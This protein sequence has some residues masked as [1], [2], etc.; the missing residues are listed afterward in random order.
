MK[1][2]IEQILKEDRRQMYLNNIIKVMKDDYPIIKNLKDYGFWEVLKKDEIEYVL[3]NLLKKGVRFVDSYYIQLLDE[4]DNLLYMEVEVGCLKGAF[5]NYVDN[6]DNISLFV[7]N[8]DCV[9]NE[10]ID[11][12]EYIEDLI[13]NSFEP[14]SLDEFLHEHWSVLNQTMKNDIMFLLNI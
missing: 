11:L 4:F 6:V 7:D 12:M 14:L 5:V 3:S 10:S 13:G 8:Y 1:K 9:W 2:I